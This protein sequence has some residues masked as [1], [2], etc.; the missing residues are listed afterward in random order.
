MDE[1]TEKPVIPTPVVQVK[2][3]LLSN[4]SLHV[5]GF[6]TRLDSALAIMQDA[7]IAIINHF[8]KGAR[9]GRLDENNSFE[10]G[11]ILTPDNK[12]PI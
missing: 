4:G 2:I 9:E 10:K 3:I 1:L 12:V 8:M 6:P 5:G 7:T 11:K